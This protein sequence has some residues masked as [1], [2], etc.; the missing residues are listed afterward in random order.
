MVKGAANPLTDEEFLLCCLDA[1][2]NINID[3]S[4]V[5]KATGYA[6]DGAARARLRKIRAKSKSLV[7]NPVQV[8]NEDE[9]GKT[10]TEKPNIKGGDKENTS[11]PTPGPRK[12]KRM[13]SND[14]KTENISTKLKREEPQ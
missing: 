7:E 13:S 5:S 9:C 2:P 14:S 6:T 8:K 1:S 12:R 10:G 3:F 4:I 11:A